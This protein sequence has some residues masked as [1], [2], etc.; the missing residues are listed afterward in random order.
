MFESSEYIAG[1]RMETK[2]IFLFYENYLQKK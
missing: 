1:N 2:Y